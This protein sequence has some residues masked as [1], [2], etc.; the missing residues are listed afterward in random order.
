MLYFIKEEK[1]EFGFIDLISI[2]FAL[3]GYWRG[4]EKSIILSLYKVVGICG[5][6]FMFYGTV[7][8]LKPLGEKWEVEKVYAIGI[9]ISVLF[10]LLVFRIL[11]IFLA[12]FLPSESG[13]GWREKVSGLI[14]AIYGLLWMSVLLKSVTY[15]NIPAIINVYRR[16]ISAKY[17]LP[18]PFKIY[19][20][21]DLVIDRAFSIGGWL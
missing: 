14:G 11:W 7:R 18:L 1:L 15:L 19:K 10:V 16:T 5:G 20:G 3:I 4:R 17:L 9:L 6:I 12:N 8:Y 13:I 2:I 21:I